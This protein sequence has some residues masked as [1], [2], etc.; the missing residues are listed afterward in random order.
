MKKLIPFSLFLL[1]GPFALALLTGKKES[2]FNKIRM[3]KVLKES[4]D[5]FIGS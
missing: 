5:L 4:E 1:A 2:A 3:G